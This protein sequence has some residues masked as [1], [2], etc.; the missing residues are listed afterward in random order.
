MRNRLIP[1]SKG[2]TEPAFGTDSVL[3]VNYII[4]QQI[5]QLLILSTLERG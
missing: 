3:A 2:R 1:I 5:M 4:F